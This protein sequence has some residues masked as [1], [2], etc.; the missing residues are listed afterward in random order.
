MKPV[1]QAIVITLICILLVSLLH[2]P[3]LAVAAGYGA[4]MVGRFGGWLFF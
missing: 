2:W 1:T 4:Y 3:L